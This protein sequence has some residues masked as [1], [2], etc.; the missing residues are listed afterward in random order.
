MANDYIGMTVE[1]GVAV[2]TLQRAEKRNALN[3]FMVQE[4]RETLKQASADKKVA[5]IM[6]KGDG[7]HFCAG[8]DIQWMHEM[9]QRSTEDN[10]EDALQLAEL[11][12]EIYNCQKPTIA[13]AHGK[14]MGG[15]LGL[16]AACDIVYAAEDA[17]FCFAEVK[18]GITPSTISPYV[19]AAIGERYTKYYFLTGESFDVKQALHIGLVQTIMPKLNLFEYSLKLAVLLQKNSLQAMIAAKELVR[20]VAAEPITITTKSMTAMHLAKIR[21]TADAQEGLQAFIEKRK[22]RWK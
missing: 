6:L 8:G 10:Y 13:L 12:Y 21:K 16:L 20:E 19:I 4:L 18:V 11:M 17:S 14:T 5:I 1:Q 2:I 3:G 15:G 7:D 22:P 9:A